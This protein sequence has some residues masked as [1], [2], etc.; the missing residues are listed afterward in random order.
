MRHVNLACCVAPMADV[1]ITC[2]V[3]GMLIAQQ[4][5][6]GS[7][8]HLGVGKI[9]SMLTAADGYLQAPCLPQSLPHNGQLVTCAQI[10]KKYTAR[11]DDAISFRMAAAKA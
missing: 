2:T 9:R 11:Q 10:D 1:G 7:R 3:D 4:M 8:V 5:A 6:S